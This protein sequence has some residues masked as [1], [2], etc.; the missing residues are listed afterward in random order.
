M[1]ARQRLRF[2]P[3]AALLL[4]LGVL[5]TT[6]PPAGGQAPGDGTQPPV[7]G[8]KPALPDDFAK[9]FTWRSIGPANMGGRIVA[10]SVFENDPTTWWAATSSAGLLK[11]TNGGL[12]L[13][14]QFDKLGVSTV[15]DVCVAPS[16][17][18]IVWV[19]TG[20][21]SGPTWG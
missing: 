13:E 8:A 6:A 19:G 3:P 14:H 1:T 2:A 7:N 10:L 16:D 5:L 21:R 18:N 11:T 12:T 17:K 4:L 9:A 15:G 20:E